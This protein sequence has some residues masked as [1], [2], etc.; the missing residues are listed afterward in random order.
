M[1]PAAEGG[2][3][4]DGESVCV[5]AALRVEA[6]RPSHLTPCYGIEGEGSPLAPK[7]PGT[8]SIH[9]LSRIV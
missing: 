8:R 1:I 6:W 9:C 7:K 3:R 5:D 4:R 2:A